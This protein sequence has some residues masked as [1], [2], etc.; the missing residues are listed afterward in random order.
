MHISLAVSLLSQLCMYGFAALAPYIPISDS[1][2]LTSLSN[3]TVPQ[4][5]GYVHPISIESSRTDDANLNRV[6]PPDPF[7][8][9]VPQSSMVITFS[10]FSRNLNREDVL[11]CL[12][13]AALEAI[14]EI[15]LGH[16]GPI[17]PR[18]ASIQTSSGHSLL[19]FYPD[20]R[21]TW[22]M[23]GTAIS[24]INKFLTDFEYVDCDFE[25]EI[26]GYPA[27]FGNGLLVHF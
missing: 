11:A 17:E 23:W 22:G 19:V 20:L 15:N 16:D 24:G 13:A 5:P 8:Y 2:N 3:W 10:H 1:L 27:D 21:I 12:L 14:K 9:R 4:P 7:S 26:L 25:I 6:L 18:D